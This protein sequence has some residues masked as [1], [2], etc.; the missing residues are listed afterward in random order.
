MPV[1]LDDETKR[2]LS[3]LVIAHDLDLI[4]EPIPYNP[5]IMEMHEHIL[6]LFRKHNLEHC[7]HNLGV[8]GV[9]RYRG[10]TVYR[11]MVLITPEEYQDLVDDCRKRNF[12]PLNLNKIEVK[13]ND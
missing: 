13:N 2:Y 10:Y 4:N 12:M 6:D 5:R 8:L 11:E 9:E 3:A 1:T 7:A